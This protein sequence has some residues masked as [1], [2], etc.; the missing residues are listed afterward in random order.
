MA[1]GIADWK[2]QG[3][4]QGAIAG[5]LHFSLT[6]PFFGSTDVFASQ[7]TEF[8]TGAYNDLTDDVAEGSTV[9]WSRGSDALMN[10]QIEAGQMS[11]QLLNAATPN[12]YDPNDPTS[13]LYGYQDVMRPVRLVSSLDSW[14]TTIGCHYGFV[15]EVDYDPDTF[16]CSITSQDI[17]ATWLDRIRPV[18][19]PQTVSSSGAVQLVLQAIGFN[20]AAYVIVDPVPAITRMNFN[21]ADGSQTALQLLAGILDAERSTFWVDGNGAFHFEG[22]YARDT[23]L[24]PSYDF[25]TGLV[26]LRSRRSMDLIGN[27][28]LVTAGGLPQIA[29]DAASIQK[30]GTSDIASI[31]SGYIPDDAR[32]MD[33]AQLLV[34]RAKDAHPPQV[35]TVDNADATTIAGQLGVDVSQ[36]VTVNGKDCFVNRIDQ[37]LHAGGQKLDTTLTTTD[38]PA[39]QTLLFS[40]TLPAFVTDSSRGFG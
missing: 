3:G 26:G 2:L 16:T 33:L 5:K 12:L 35:A 8:F 19:T 4:W 38:V 30:Y 27:R 14:A 11:F 29:T 18:I 13:P 6:D 21:A 15:S 28:A 22:R 9:G 10:A 39:T 24:T 34:A 37:A 31:T 20:D 1:G 32:A 17:T 25:E 40:T 23:K 7:W 36:R